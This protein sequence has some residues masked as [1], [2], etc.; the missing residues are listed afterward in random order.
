M[1]T[2][3]RRLPVVPITGEHRRERLCRLGSSL[4]ILGVASAAHD[5][6]GLAADPL[7]LIVGAAG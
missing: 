4:L 6:W 2:V 7:V 1:I 3:P 5:I